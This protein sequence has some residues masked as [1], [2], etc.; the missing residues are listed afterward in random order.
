MERHLL[1]PLALPLLA[2]ALAT[3]AGRR[4][5]T[6]QISFAA[7]LLNLGYAIWLLLRVQT[8]GRQVSQIGSLTAS[9]GIVLVAD[10]LSALLLLLSALLL[11]VALLFA[12]VSLDRQREHFYFYPLVLLLLAGLN[13]ISL[14]GDI[15]NLY[16]WFEV[17][18]AASAG[19]LILGGGRAQLASGLNYLV[20]HMLGS[21]GLLIGCGLTYGLAGT[22]NMAR[23]GEQFATIPGRGLLTVLACIFLVAYG[24]RAAIFPLFFWLPDSYHIPPAAVSII[25]G[26]LLTRAGMYA[27]YRIFSLVYP[28]ALVQLA[29][30]FLLL[31]ALTMLVGVL[32]AMSQTHIRRILAFLVI[33]QTGYM[34]MGLG[35]ASVGGLTAGLLFLAHDAL[36]LTALFCLG[37]TAEHIS[38][39]GDIEQ[40]GGLARREPVLAMLW[41]LCLLSLVGLPP[42][43]GFFAR[44]LLLQAALAQNAYGW[45]F[46]I[47]LASL[48][49]LIPMLRIWN[50]VFWKSLPEGVPLPRRVSVAQIIPAALLAGLLLMFGLAIAPVVDYSMMAA[51][52]AFDMPGYIADVLGVR[53]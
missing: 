31:A 27:L 50:E 26:G 42:L 21:A 28:N 39:T 11:P 23:L 38:R 29:P 1:L 5:L 47:T 35:L 48:L 44:L 40:M 18:L 49:Q 36:V 6:R 34:L 16:V 45:M 15:F 20:L 24:T 53:P 10:G 33:S 4:D 7:L 12:A 8:A 32:G 19:L 9:Y 22:V 17:L 52:Q 41:L 43:G 13:G 25:F 3:I 37:S 51:Q 30:L 2:A 46:I 14:T